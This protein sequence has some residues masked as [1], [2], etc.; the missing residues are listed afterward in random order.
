ML[1]RNMV[2]GKISLRKILKGKFVPQSFFWHIWLLRMDN[3]VVR[4]KGI[5][6][7]FP[8]LNMT[9]CQLFKKNNNNLI[10]ILETLFKSIINA[11]C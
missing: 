9:G 2:W 1:R 10:L 6:P 11:K 8:M 7:I 4:G 5:I 3:W